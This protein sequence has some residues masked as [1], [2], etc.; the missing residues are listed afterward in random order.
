MSR[1]NVEFVRESIRRFADGD[2]E[3]L[4]MWASPSRSGLDR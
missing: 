1:E 3:G 2:L 4:R